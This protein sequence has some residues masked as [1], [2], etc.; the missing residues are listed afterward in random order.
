MTGSTIFFLF[1]AFTL[2]ILIPYL[3]IKD[4]KSGKKKI[5]IFTSN[6]VTLVL[7]LISV[8]EVLRTM[9]SEHTMQYF[10]QILFLFIIIFVV[11]PLIIIQ[12]YNIKNDIKKWNDPKE[13]KHYWAYKY[14]YILLTIF[15][16]IFIGAIYRFYL[17]YKI[18]FA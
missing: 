15:S 16:M 8:A 6:I 7:F 5:E 4:I 3:I 11:S 17:I 1:A 9:I 2:L 10:N 18:L 14:R 12:F 13:Y